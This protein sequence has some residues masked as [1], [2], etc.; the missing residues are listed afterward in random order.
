MEMNQKRKPVLEGR[1]ITV[2][3]GEGCDY[4]ANHKILEKGRCPVCGTIWA[5]RD[6]NFQLYPGEILGIVGESGSGKSTLLKTLYFEQPVTKGEAYLS[7]YRD[8][9]ANIFDTS[10]QNKRYLRNHLMGMVYQNPMLGLRMRLS[11]GANIAEKLIAAGDRNARKMITRCNVLLEQVEIPV[12][13]MKDAPQV[14]SG[15]MQQRVQ[16]SK[17]IANNPPVLFLDE[18]TTGLDLSVQAKVLDQIRTIQQ[19]LGIAMMIVSHDLA[20]IRMMSD[21]TMVMLGGRVVEEGLT[22]QILEDPLHIY[23]QTLVSSLL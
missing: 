16:I 23:T 17:A 11:S 20:V 8:G 13:R 1:N 22:D 3:F 21:R 6:V 9:R 14:F 7:L 18:V 4:C 2:R 12:E 15:G 10:G 5:V 19:E